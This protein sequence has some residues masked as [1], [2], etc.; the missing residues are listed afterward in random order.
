MALRGIDEKEATRNVIVYV[1]PGTIVPLKVHCCGFVPEEAVLM[2]PI[3]VSPSS[4]VIAAATEPA[5]PPH[6]GPPRAT[7]PVPIAT[8]ATGMIAAPV[9][10]RLP[11]M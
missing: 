11:T 5:I 7:Q 4:V 8:S 9:P 10:E 6:A 2:T 3:E 1:A